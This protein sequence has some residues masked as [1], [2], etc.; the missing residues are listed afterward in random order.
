MG[1][2]TAERSG[3]LADVVSAAD[4]CGETGRKGDRGEASEWLSEGWV[5]GL[6]VLP[7]VFMIANWHRAG[8]IGCR[9]WRPT[10]ART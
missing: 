3:H 4:G 10:G 2:S 8:W 6:S 9:W 7:A 5:I 1:P